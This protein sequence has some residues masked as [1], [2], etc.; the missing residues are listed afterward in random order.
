MGRGCCHADAVA[1]LHK[2]VA[3]PEHPAGREQHAVADVVPSP[4]KPPA[5]QDI[6]NVREDPDAHLGAAGLRALRSVRA[7]Y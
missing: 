6:H 1:L 2:R 5:L 4:G 3:A 7:G